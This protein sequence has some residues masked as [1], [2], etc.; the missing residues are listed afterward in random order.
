MLQARPLSCYES[1]GTETEMLSW[2]HL[3]IVVLAKL[4]FDLGSV[5]LRQATAML[6][7]D[8]QAGKG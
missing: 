7:T 1:R 6:C 8:Q 2:H 4:L 3:I 5:G